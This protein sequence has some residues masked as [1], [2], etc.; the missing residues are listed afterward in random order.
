MSYSL[1]TA[2]FHP[3][4]KPFFNEIMEQP[5]FQEIQKK[6]NYEAE[7]FNGTLEIFP[8][9]NLLYNAFNLSPK[10]IRV[11]IIG[12]DPYIRKG[13][14]MGLSFSV[15]DGVSLPPSLR[16]IYKELVASGM[17]ND[18]PTTGNL[19]KWANQGVFLLNAALT[20]LEGRSN[21]HAKEWAPFTDGCIRWLS[22]NTTGVVFMLWGNFAKGKKKF[23]SPNGHLVLE[24]SHPSPLAGKPFTGCGHF[25]KANDYLSEND[26]SPIDWNPHD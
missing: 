8:P 25:K 12:Q 24:W 20:V 9:H 15:P 1:T 16:N 10:D 18:F 11:V 13:Q 14:A 23:I 6:I 21:R 26:K 2:N 22:E 5:F 7:I 19:T 3:D 4:W 17:V